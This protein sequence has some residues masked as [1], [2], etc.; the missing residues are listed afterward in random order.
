MNLI[1]KYKISKITNKVSNDIE[2]E[3]IL[4]IK[5][6]LSDLV[7]YTW[8]KMPDYVYYI[9]KNN[10]VVLSCVDNIIYIRWYDF[11]TVLENKYQVTN[12]DIQ[13]IFRLMVKDSI[14]N[15]IGNK[16]I[17]FRWTQNLDV[18]EAYINNKLNKEV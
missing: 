14:E 10:Q 5:D 1:R 3:I 13:S 6:W 16:V 8:N 12:S 18:E 4:F 9:N 2:G 17:F 7:A 11:Y 15:K